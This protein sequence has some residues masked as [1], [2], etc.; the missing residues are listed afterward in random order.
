MKTKNYLRMLRSRRNI[1]QAE[2]ARRLNISRQAVNGFEAENYEPS[3]SVATQIA[4]ILN[5]PV[6]AIFQTDMESP[7][8]LIAQFETDEE[9]VKFQKELMI[10]FHQDKLQTV[11]LGHQGASPRWDWDPQAER[12]DG[13]PA[14]AVPC[15]SKRQFDEMVIW[16]R[17]QGCKNIDCAIG[18][19]GGWPYLAFFAADTKYARDQLSDWQPEDA[20]PLPPTPALDDL[21]MDQASWAMVVGALND[22]TD[23]ATGFLNKYHGNLQTD[24]ISHYRQMIA[25]MKDLRNQMVH[26]QKGVTRWSSKHSLMIEALH[27]AEVKA[28]NAEDMTLAKAY[29]E[30]RRKIEDQANTADVDRSTK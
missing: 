12:T 25:Q 22:A 26:V 30:T 10:I 20:E 19:G 23:E 4:A 13:A 3:I 27:A 21:Y 1:S 7:V 11:V 9:R 15:S 16:L 5:V 6:S 28:R 24:Y 29:F 18:M 2:L 14:L 8:A 17:Q